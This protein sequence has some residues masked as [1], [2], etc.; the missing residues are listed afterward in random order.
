MDETYEDDQQQRSAQQAEQELRLQ[1]DIDDIRHVM[2]S[3][4]GR[5]IIWDVLTQGKVFGAIL[6]VDALAMAFQEGQRNVSLAL[7][8]RVMANCPEQY[9][10]MAAEASEDK[11]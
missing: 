8:Q 2:D 10:K 7:F 3:E 1:R 11:V 4:Q 6:P 5:R 9:L